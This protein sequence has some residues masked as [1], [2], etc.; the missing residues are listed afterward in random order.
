MNSD[1]IVESLQPFG[2]IG[3]FQSDKSKG[4][5]A[6]ADL[7]MHGM[8]AECASEFGHP[9]MLSAL[10]ELQERVYRVVNAGEVVGGQLS[11]PAKELNHG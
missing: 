5:R 3:I 7:F 2:V 1:Q 6:K 11:A 10:Q 9:T 8:K 4:F